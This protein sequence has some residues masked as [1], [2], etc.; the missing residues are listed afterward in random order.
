MITITDSSEVRL[1]QYTKERPG[2]AHRYYYD[3]TIQDEN[4]LQNLTARSGRPVGRLARRD[5]RSNQ[6]RSGRMYSSMKAQGN[7]TQDP[8]FSTKPLSVS[9]P[10]ERSVSLSALARERDHREQVLSNMNG[11]RISSETRLAILRKQ[12]DVS[13]LRS[14]VVRIRISIC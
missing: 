6:S 10:V 11:G 5:L 4:H 14:R 12:G 9:G 1:R 8:R 7:T 13:F 2:T 3:H